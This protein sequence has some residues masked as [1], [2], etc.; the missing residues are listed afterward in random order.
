MVETQI[1]MTQDHFSLLVTSL[2][3][4][5]S[6]VCLFESYLFSHWQLFYVLTFLKWKEGLSVTSC[7][8]IL[9]ACAISTYL[10]SLLTFTYFRNTQ[11]SIHQFK[12]VI[13]LWEQQQIKTITFCMT[14]QKQ[15]YKSLY[16]QT[17]TQRNETTLFYQVIC[18]YRVFRL[19]AAV[20][21]PLWTMI[22]VVI[23][24]FFKMQLTLFK[25]IVFVFFLCILHN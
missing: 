2:S 19:T 8:S 16:R 15:R 1:Q 10:M 24:I 23:N 17:Q 4:F 12:A 22:F 3:L 21:E 7:D 5:P 9:R 20:S 14:F 25:K 18:V 13:N 11:K 6:A